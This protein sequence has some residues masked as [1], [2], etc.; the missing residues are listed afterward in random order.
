MYYRESVINGVLHYRNHPT[1]PWI[2]FSATSMTNK[3]IASQM[4]VNE[5]TEQLEQLIAMAYLD[6]MINRI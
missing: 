3:Y 2:P 4:I 6:V 5:L 1:S